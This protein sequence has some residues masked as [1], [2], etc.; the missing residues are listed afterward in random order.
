MDLSFY[1]RRVWVHALAFS[2][3]E[4]AIAE[5][6]RDTQRIPFANLIW[7]D[8]AKSW[9]LVADLLPSPAHRH[10]PPSL[11]LLKDFLF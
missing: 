4:R 11:S 6:L 5:Y 2:P 1:L 10:T 8:K 7:S 9:L 3:A